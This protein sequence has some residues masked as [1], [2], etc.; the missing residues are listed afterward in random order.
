M[1]MNEPCFFESETFDRMI[2]FSVTYERLEIG[3]ELISI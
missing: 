1:S 3:V 2:K